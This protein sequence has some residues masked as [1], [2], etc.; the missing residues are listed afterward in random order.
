MTGIAID[1]YLRWG[2]FVVHLGVSKCPSNHD[3][4][5]S[6]SGSVGVEV[7]R[8][9]PFR[10]QKLTCLKEDN[11]ASSSLTTRVLHVPV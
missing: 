7:A 4:I 11:E 8:S 1:V 2:H 6:A 5:V 10:L 3:L 9:K